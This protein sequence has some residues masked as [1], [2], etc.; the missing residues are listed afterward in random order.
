VERYI[1]FL[2]AGNS[3]Y[4]VEVLKRAGVDLSTPQPVEET[5]QVLEGLVER[6]EKLTTAK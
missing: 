6:L 4:P 3:V 2:S 5:Y 1:N